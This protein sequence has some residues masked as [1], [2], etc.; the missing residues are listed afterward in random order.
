MDEK[1]MLIADLRRE[2]TALKAEVARLRSLLAPTPNLPTDHPA[3]GT[4]KE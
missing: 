1:D 2:N 3:P 4:M